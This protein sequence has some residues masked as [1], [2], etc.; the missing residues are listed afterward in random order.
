MKTNMG[1]N[2]LIGN[3]LGTTSFLYR[4]RRLTMWKVGADNYHNANFLTF[5]PD[6][7][8]SGNLPE[9]TIE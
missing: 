8:N 3:L 2:M 4:A 5:S 7:K 6:K 9:K 1:F